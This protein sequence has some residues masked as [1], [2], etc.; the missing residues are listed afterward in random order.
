MV[1]ETLSHENGARILWNTINICFSWNEKSSNI[2]NIKTVTA[3]T[4]IGP[5]PISWLFIEVTGSYDN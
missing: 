1:I 2:G 3:I 4:K 5:R